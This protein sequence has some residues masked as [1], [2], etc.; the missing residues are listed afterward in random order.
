MLGKRLPA[1]SRPSRNRTGTRR[2]EAREIDGFLADLPEPYREELT[3]LFA[4]MTALETPESKIYKALDKLE[5]VLQH[6][7]AD[8]GTWLPLEYDLQ[9]TYGTAETGFSDYMRR[10]K[11]ELNEDSKR[12]IKGPC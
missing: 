2:R 10:L 6:N 1:T 8:I 9:L 5:A 12:K 4:D 7:E 3:A 11:K